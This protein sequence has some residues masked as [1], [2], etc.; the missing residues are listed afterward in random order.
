[1]FADNYRVLANKWVREDQIKEWVDGYSVSNRRVKSFMKASAIDPDTMTTILKE[2]AELK[3]QGGIIR[4][5]RLYIQLVKE[6]APAYECITCGRGHLHRG[7]GICT[8][9]HTSLPQLPNLTAADLRERNYI[10]KRLEKVFADEQVSFRL[11]CEELTGQT[12]SPA[13]RLRRFR[14]LWLIQK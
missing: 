3:H 2:L 13:E 8:R 10:S 4:I 5:E 1:M 12:S 6:D 11:R 9:C 14:E 7:T